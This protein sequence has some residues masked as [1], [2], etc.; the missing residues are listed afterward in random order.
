[1]PSVT[2]QINYFDSDAQQRNEVEVIYNDDLEPIQDGEMLENEIE[3]TDNRS[4]AAPTSRKRRRPDSNQRVCNKL[5]EK[6]IE[7][8]DSKIA[9]NRTKQLF[10][11]Q[12][13]KSF[14]P[15]FQK[16]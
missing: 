6:Q 3:E 4:W 12:K 5:I 15:N 11:D 9:L 2:P 7:A 13:M 10:Y 1:M 8:L 16:E 14:Q